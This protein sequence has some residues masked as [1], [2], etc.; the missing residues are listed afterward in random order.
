MVDDVLRALAEPR[1]RDILR[2]IQDREL[3]SGEIALHF[4]VT[5]PAI[6][7]HLQVLAEAGLVTVRREG[8][9]RL[10]QARPEGFTD[11]RAFLEDFWDVQLR[12]LKRAAEAEERRLR[13]DEH[14]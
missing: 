13:R 1:R 11:L 5:R 14:P 3:S 9:K 6:S 12:R 10:Y 4:D 8:T 2:L 7:Q